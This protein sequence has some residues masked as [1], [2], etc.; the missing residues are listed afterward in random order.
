MFCFVLALLWFWTNHSLYLPSLS[1][2]MADFF[3]SPRKAT[4]ALSRGS[5]TLGDSG[6]L[7]LEAREKEAQQVQLREAGAREAGKEGACSAG[8]LTG[9]EGLLGRREVGARLGGQLHTDLSSARV[10]PSLLSGPAQPCDSPSLS[11]VS[12]SGSSHHSCSLHCR[13][14]PVPHSDHS[15]LSQ[16]KANPAQRPQTGREGSVRPLDASFS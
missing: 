5:G 3:S 12:F 7:R 8:A 15:S 16:G 2:C 13:D 6:F 4:L 10:A 11:A 14:G 1:F 9:Q